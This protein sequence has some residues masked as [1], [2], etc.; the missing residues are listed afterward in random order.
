MHFATLLFYS[1]KSSASTVIT[2][3]I[4][5]PC[6]DEEVCTLKSTETV[7][8]KPV[9]KKNIPCSDEEEV[10]T[11]KSTCT[12]TVKG[13]LVSKKHIPNTS[14]PPPVP[15]NAF[16]VYSPTGGSGSSSMEVEV[17]TPT[18]KWK[19][20]SQLLIDIHSAI[21]ALHFR[22]DYLEDI[23]KNY[24]SA[25]PYRRHSTPSG[26]YSSST[27]SNSSF[28]FHPNKQTEMVV[29]QE[30]SYLPKLQ[31]KAIPP[32]QGTTEGQIEDACLKL[33]MSP[34]LVKMID[35][36]SHSRKNLAAKLVREV[37]S[38]EERESSNVM[39]LKGKRRLDPT[40]MSVVRGLTFAMRPV[41][42]GES[43]DEL[44]RTECI[45]A[46]DTANRSAKN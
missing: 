18:C 23:L 42:P 37:F 7:E 8:G 5:E 33:G 36:D 9:S 24:T 4:G 10:C 29:K 32:S 40:R 44:W 31:H 17:G 41:K 20:E 34:N 21:L 16:Q 30:T 26:S 19:G 25:I 2:L 11:V 3:D 28:Q 6:S 46:I 39:G 43:E 27:E 14:S 15:R 35:K 22:M 13:K 12:E 1:Q 38:Y 45:K